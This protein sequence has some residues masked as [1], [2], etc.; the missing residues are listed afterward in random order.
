MVHNL[1]VVGVEAWSYHEATSNRME[2]LRL[3]AACLFVWETQ[4]F[5]APL[6]RR[7]LMN[8]IILLKIIL[9]A[10]ERL[11]FLAGPSFRD[12]NNRVVVSTCCQFLI[13]FRLSPSR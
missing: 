9:E 3:L 10:L 5:D 1:L 6:H 7:T 2:F 4:Q 12:T 11:Y 8:T 13:V